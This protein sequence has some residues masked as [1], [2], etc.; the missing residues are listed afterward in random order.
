[1]DRS[2]AEIGPKNMNLWAVDSFRWSLIS[3]A[4]RCRAPREGPR[5]AELNSK[6]AASPDTA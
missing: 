6:V 3:R 1:M 5:P 4:G 2:R